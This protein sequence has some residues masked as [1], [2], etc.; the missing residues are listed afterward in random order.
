MASICWTLLCAILHSPSSISVHCQG[1][2]E[3]WSSYWPPSTTK[4]S[5]FVK[6]LSDGFFGVSWT[7]IASFGE[8]GKLFLP[9]LFFATLEK[10]RSRSD[11]WQEHTLQIKVLVG[12]TGREELY[13]MGEMEVMTKWD[14]PSWYCLSADL[15]LTPFTS[16]TT[17]P[18]SREMEN[19]S[20]WNTSTGI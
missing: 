17:V 16:M 20:D 11:I 19:T 18:L 9:S 12:G 13:L 15:T 7:W 6:Q 14:S 4:E 2:D 1:R 3:N 5:A 8:E 10:L